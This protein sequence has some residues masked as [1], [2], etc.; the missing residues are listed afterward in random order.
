MRA[1]LESHPLASLL[2]IIGAI[3]MSLLVLLWLDTRKDGRH[4]MQDDEPGGQTHV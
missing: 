4:A 1:I 2:V 3:A